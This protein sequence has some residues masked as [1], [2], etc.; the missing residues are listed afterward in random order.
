MSGLSA[1]GA[2]LMDVGSLTEAEVAGSVCALE[3]FTVL[4]HNISIF[5]TGQQNQP[6]RLGRK[7]KG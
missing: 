1:G 6:G 3:R 4:R 7:R 2:S 5:R